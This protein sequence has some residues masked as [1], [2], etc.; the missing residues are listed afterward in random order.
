MLVQVRQK[1]RGDFVAT[2]LELPD[3]RVIVTDTTGE[4][5][6]L[7]ASEQAWEQANTP[8]DALE[9]F[10]SVTDAFLEVLPAPQEI[11]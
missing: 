11:T 10:D 9:T 1:A 6:G 7:F 8:Y 5:A 4:G 3:G 2:I